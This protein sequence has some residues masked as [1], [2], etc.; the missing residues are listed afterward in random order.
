MLSNALILAGGYAGFRALIQGTKLPSY[1]NDSF[2]DICRN[3]GYTAESYTVTTDD[4]YNLKLFRIKHKS[5]ET[6]GEPVLLVHGL[7]QSA[8]CFIINKSALA[9]AFRLASSG[10][11]V[12]LLNCRGSR[13]SLSNKYYSPDT[14]NFWY[15]TAYDI[16]IR[17]LPSSINFILS[18]TQKPSLNYIGYSQGGHVLLNLLSFDPSFNSKIKLAS[19]LAPVT[20]TIL[21]EAPYFSRLI[22]ERQLQ[23]FDLKK[24]YSSGQH[25]PGGTFHAKLAFEFPKLIKY[26]YADRFNPEY[27]NDSFEHFP[28]YLTQ[29]AGGTSVLNLKYYKQLKEL[30]MACPLAYDFRDRGQNFNEYRYETPPVADYRLITAKLALFY[31]R[32]DKIVSPNDGK[33]FMQQLGKDVVVYKDFDRKIDHG[34]FIL[35]KDLGHFDQI[36]AMI[37][38]R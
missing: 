2:E 27:T 1:Y 36:S 28:Y 30:N 6:R 5:N 31:G 21:G 22:S 19:L 13:Y 8:V 24:Q 14:K 35:S 23:I 3:S 18:S 7:T 12:W 10:H 4:G 20:G 26:L 17:D 11:D 25:V 34:G 37:K 29:L 33:I 38:S 15:W 16:S 9:P 32:F